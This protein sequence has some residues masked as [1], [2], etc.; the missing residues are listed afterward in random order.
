MKMIIV[1]PGLRAPI[2]APAFSRKKA[3]QQVDR[4]KRGE[5]NYIRL[6]RNRYLKIDIGVYWRLLS[7]N[8]GGDWELM[9]HERYSKAIKK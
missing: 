4:F 2:T 6:K 5:R 9:P 8:D 7:R 3:C 1:M